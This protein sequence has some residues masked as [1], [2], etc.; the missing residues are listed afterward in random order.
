[1]R[2]REL[3]EEGYRSHAPL[4]H[5]ARKLGVTTA[6]LNTCCRLTT[7]KSA[8]ALI[9]ERLLTEAKRTLLY[10]D[11]TVNEIGAALGYADQAYFNRFFSRNVGLS[12]G[13]FRDN[14]LLR[15]NGTP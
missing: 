11:V 14:L 13:R 1:M 2:F 3:V 15:D 6:R 12:P 5:Y 7:G 10:S 9:N 4:D 8:L